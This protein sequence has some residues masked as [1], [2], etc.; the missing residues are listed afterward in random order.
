MLI[1]SEIKKIILRNFQKPA[2]L[3]KL[4][5]CVKRFII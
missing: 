2:L 3:K 1:E 4:K 5:T